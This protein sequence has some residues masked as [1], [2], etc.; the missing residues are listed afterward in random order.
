MSSKDSTVRVREAGRFA[1]EV[2]V[3]R[4]TFVVDEPAAVGGQDAGP[5]PYDL[6]LAALGACTSMTL[7]MY[8]ER[9]GW[10]LGG[11]SVELSHSRIHARDCAECETEHGLLDRIERQIH[12]DGPLSEEQHRRLMEIAD[13]CP[14]HRTLTSEIVIS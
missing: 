7:R 3:G 13:R 10:P 9:K 1:Q 8:A 14:V 4:H 11:V 5:T 2:T 12:L 6:L